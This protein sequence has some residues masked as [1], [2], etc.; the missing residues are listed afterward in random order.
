MGQCFS[1]VEEY[2]YDEIPQENDDYVPGDS[3]IIVR[4][5]GFESYAVPVHKIRSLFSQY[6]IQGQIGKHQ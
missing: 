1:Y 2:D 3:M 4:V 6:H 5:S